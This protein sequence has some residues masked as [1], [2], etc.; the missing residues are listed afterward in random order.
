M[1][2][3]AEDDEVLRWS[4]LKRRKK[5]LMKLNSKTIKRKKPK[6]IMREVVNAVG[7]Y[8]QRHHRRR[9]HRR[10]IRN[11]HRLI[12]WSN[13]KRLFASAKRPLSLYTEEGESSD[14]TNEQIKV[15]INES[16]YNDAKKSPKKQTK[17]PVRRSENCVVNEDSF[18]SSTNINSL[19]SSQTKTHNALEQKFKSSS[20]TNVP[21]FDSSVVAADLTNSHG[22]LDSSLFS[23]SYLP[24]GSSVDGSANLD[25]GLNSPELG[26]GEQNI[27]ESESGAKMLYELHYPSPEEGEV[28]DARLEEEWEPFDP[29]YFIKHLPP[30]SSDVRARCPA[31]PLRTRSSPE[32]SLVLDLDETLVHCSLQELD[33]ASLSFPVYFQDCTYQVFVRTRPFFREFL[34]RVSRIFEVT[35]FTA[36]K[37][38]YADKLMNLLDPDRRLIKYRLFREH[39]VCVNGNYIKDLTILG[40]DLAKTIIVDNSPQA[41]GYQLENGIPIESWFTDSTDRELMKLV[42]FLESLVAMNEDVRPHIRDK[43]RLFAH[44]PPD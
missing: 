30:L 44:L 5:Q 25:L 10:Q 20:W 16:C 22:N 12:T 37:K 34:E 8:F 7:I 38:V 11:G 33:N 19:V 41:F 28:A 36:S 4:K 32:F 14:G 31:L 24:F 39:C 27:Q 43:Y 21:K 18:I 1:N 2:T 9:H 3:I 15:F 13:H 17:C 42:P 40:R 23:P 6:S 26:E 29:Y 35:L